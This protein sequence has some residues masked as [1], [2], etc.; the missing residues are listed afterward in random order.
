MLNMDVHQG[1]WS[2]RD[3]TERALYFQPINV[4]SSY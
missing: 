2:F 3:P 1:E 4:I